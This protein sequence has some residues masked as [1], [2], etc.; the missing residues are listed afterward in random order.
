M[1]NGK[2]IIRYR[3]NWYCS[4]NVDEDWDLR[5]SGWR[6]LIEGETPIDINVTFPVRPEQVSSSM[7]AILRGEKRGSS[8]FRYFF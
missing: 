3:L 6:L 7:A 8:S 5:R 2:A 1:L 4:T